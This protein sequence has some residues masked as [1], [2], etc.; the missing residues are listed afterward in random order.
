MRG[1]GV[2]V[3]TRHSGDGERKEMAMRSA[4]R[5]EDDADSLE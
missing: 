4:W 3:K 2:S 1:G 5:C